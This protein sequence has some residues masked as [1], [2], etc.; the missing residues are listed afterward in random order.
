MLDFSGFAA[1]ATMEVDV[2]D[3]LR[4]GTDPGLDGL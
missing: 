2:D 4:N 3:I 1:V